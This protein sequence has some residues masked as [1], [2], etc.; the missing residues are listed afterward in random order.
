MGADRWGRRIMRELRGWRWAWLGVATTIVVPPFYLCQDS[1]ELAVFS[2]VL[3]LGCTVVGRS[4]DHE[5]S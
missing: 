3:G 1:Q 2:V 5:P 4:T